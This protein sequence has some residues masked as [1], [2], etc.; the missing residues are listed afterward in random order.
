M[1]STVASQLE[2]PGYDSWARALV[3][4]HCMSLYVL[5]VS[6]WGPSG[7]SSLLLQSKD[8]QVS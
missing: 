7:Y 6:A 4:A 8:M 3:V 1:I 2:R 5:P